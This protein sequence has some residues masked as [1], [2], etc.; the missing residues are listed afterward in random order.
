M[1]DIHEQLIQRSKF[2]FPES[3]ALLSIVDDKCRMV[4]FYLFLKIRPNI[5]K[6]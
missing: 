5:R 6:C 3:F 4:Y 1:F 2:V